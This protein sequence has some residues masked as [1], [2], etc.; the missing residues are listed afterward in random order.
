MESDSWQD[1]VV[2]VLAAIGLAG[3]L[4]CSTSS[5]S[6]APEFAM[7][8][9][10]GP[11]VIP[12]SVVRLAIVYPQ[13]TD[14]ALAGIYSHLEAE[15]FLLKTLRPSLQIV[16]R[17]HLQPLLDEYRLQGSGVVSDDTSARIGHL[18]GADSL[19]LYRVDRPTLRERMLALFSGRLP[20]VRVFSKVI[21]VNTGEVVFHHVVS[22]QVPDL[23]DDAMYSS[24]EPLVQAAVNAGVDQTLLA[25]QDAFRE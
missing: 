20:P 10:A 7:V 25:L 3:L 1:R 11:T 18:L 8:E 13:S 16:E 2:A 6:A 24:L 9:Q 22:V 12:P 4:S 5:L 19:L 23:S 15:T 21:L 14:P 17:V